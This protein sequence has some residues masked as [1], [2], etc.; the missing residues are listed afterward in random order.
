MICNFH[1]VCLFQ[2]ANY[3]GEK[4]CSGLGSVDYGQISALGLNDQFSSATVP[5][6]L[7]VTV[8]E[9][10]FNGGTRVYTED[11]SFFSDF[12]DIISSFIVSEA[13]I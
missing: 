7:R 12:N 5:I 1:S 13:G 3:V 11:T 10:N 4:I 2:H 8:Y 6:G 9:H